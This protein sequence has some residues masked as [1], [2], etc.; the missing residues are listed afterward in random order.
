[1]PKPPCSSQPLIDLIREHVVVTYE[2]LRAA[3]GSVSR[4]TVYRKMVEAGC[5]SSYS[6][7]GRYYTLDTCA[8]YDPQ[9]LWFYQDIRFSQQG[10]LNATLVNLVEQSSGGLFARELRH[11]V[12][13]ELHSVLPRLVQRGRLSRVK[14]GGQYLYV[15]S[16]AK[17][18]RHQQHT[19]AHPVTE[20][21]DTFVQAQTRMFETLDEKQRR[22]FVGLESLR[23]NSGGD[24]HVAERFRVARATVTKGR[25]QLLSGDFEKDRIRKAG[26]GRKSAEKKTP[27]S[28][29]T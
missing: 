1:M 11:I 29:S 13:L 5:R 28:T 27:N 19:H 16:N 6:H 22:L 12:Q 14:R 7:G 10:T 25:Q 3:L 23:P 24:L 17:K 20:F 26:G 18:R 9:G 8:D 4:Q 15:S 2:D 21:S